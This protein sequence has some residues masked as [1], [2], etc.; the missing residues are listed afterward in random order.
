MRALVAPLAAFLLAGCSSTTFAE[1]RILVSPYLAAYQLRGSVG[2]QSQPTVGTFQDN[3]PQ[4][5]RTFGQDHHREDFGIRA[6]IGD[7]FAGARLDYYKLDMGTSKT[8]VLGA[9]WGRLLANDTV[10]M[11]AEMDEVRIGYLD[12]IGTMR[13]TLRDRPLTLRFAAGGVLSHRSLALKARTA[14]GA[15]S[16]NAEIEGDALFLATRFRAQWRDWSFDTDY[17]ISPQLVLG[18]DFEN[19]MQDLELRVAYAVPMHDVTFFGGYRFSAFEA[20]GRADVYDYRADLQIDGFQVG[21]SV[22][23]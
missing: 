21:V 17:A 12:S 13:A 15:R 7:G 6:D 18:G 3:A 8:G 10:R 19:V 2:M 16:Q 5:M 20:K 23:F 14:D 22:S 9:D 1:P 4:T 11:A